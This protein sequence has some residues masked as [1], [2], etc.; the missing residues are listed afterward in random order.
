MAKEK[1]T[2]SRRGGRKINK[3]RGQKVGTHCTPTTTT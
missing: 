1:H 3:D 2:L